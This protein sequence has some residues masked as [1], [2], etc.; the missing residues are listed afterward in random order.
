MCNYMYVSCK[1]CGVSV[2][3]IIMTSIFAP[4]TSEYE[5]RQKGNASIK[6]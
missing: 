6:K 4:F 1:G 5:L 2:R 3:I